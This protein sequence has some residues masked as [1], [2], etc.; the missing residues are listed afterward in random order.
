METNWLG[1]VVGGGLIGLSAVLLLLFNGR[2]AG[3]SGIVGTLLVTKLSYDGLWR[4][5]FV[6]GLLIGSGI[7]LVVQ[8]DLPIQ[9]QANRAMLIVAGL[10]VGLGTR[11]GSGCTSGHGVCGIARHSKRSITATLVFMIVAMLTVYIKRAVGL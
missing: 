6:I 1:G 10:L 2:I 11:I 5:M 4:I 9:M 3:I 7:Y 8:G